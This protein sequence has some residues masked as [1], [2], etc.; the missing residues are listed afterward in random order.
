MEFLSQSQVGQDAFAHSLIGN[1]GTFL[2]I[3]CGDQNGSNTLALEWVGWTGYLVEL[4]HKRAEWCRQ[5]RRSPIIEGDA[6]RIDWGLCSKRE[7]DYLS[8]DI[9]DVKGEDSKIAKV[10]LDLLDSGFT[11]KVMTIEHD[12]YRIGN[13]TR[14]LIRAI[15]PTRGY[16]LARADVK[17]KGNPFE[18]WWTRCES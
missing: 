4:D 1:S 12:S 18:D 6:T 9:D 16:T 17:C 11:F 10:L 13:G 3:G 8:L 5:N 14:D 7:F 15:L 2:D